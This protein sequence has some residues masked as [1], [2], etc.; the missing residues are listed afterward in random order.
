MYVAPPAGTELHVRFGVAVVVGAAGDGQIELTGDPQIAGGCGRVMIGMVDFEAQQS[1]V[2]QAGED[3][4]FLAGVL[5]TEPNG[6]SDD[7]NAARRADLL[8]GFFNGGFVHGDEGGGVVT[9]VEFKGLVDG[10]DVALVAQEAGEV[11]AAGDG[12]SEGF[13]GGERDIEMEGLEPQHHT[14]VALPAGLLHLAEPIAKRGRRTIAEEVGQQMGG[15]ARVF[16]ESGRDFD[17]A[18]E[19][20]TGYA[21]GF[22]GGEVAVEGVVIGDG[23]GAQ[24][25]EGGLFDEASRRVSAIGVIRMGVKVNQIVKMKFMRLTALIFCFLVLFGCQRKP[26]DDFLIFE[27]D[28]FNGLLAFQ[29]TFGTLSGIHQYDEFL[30]DRSRG[31]IE[32]R[33]EELRVQAARLAALREDT[34][35]VDEAI[36]AEILQKRIEAELLEFTEERSWETNPMLYTGLPGAAIDSLL[37]RDFAPGRERIPAL[38]ERLRTVPRL[39]EAMKMNVRNPPREFT[40][41]AL[42]MAQGSVTYFKQTVPKWAAPFA[43]VEERG[44]VEKAALMAQLAM[45]DAVKWLEKEARPQSKG[46]FA[47]GRERFLKKLRA[48]EMI[49]TPLP[50][51]LAIGEQALVRDRARFAKVAAAFAPAATMAQVMSRLADDHPREGELLSV[52]RGSLERAQKFLMD[53]K[54]ITLP[55]NLRPNVTETP[56]FARNG[57]FASMDSPGAFETRS[58]EAYYYIT[59]PEREWSAVRRREHL[60]L[61]SRPVLEMITIHEAFPGHYVHFLNA[62]RF[63]TKTRKLLT[64]GSTV[65]GWAHYAEQMMM[66]QG[67]GGADPRLE[68][69]QLSEALV[70]DCRFIAGIKLHTEGWSVAQAAKFFAGQAGQEPANAEEEALR[71]TYNPTYL[72]YT[73]GKLMVYELRRDFARERGKNYTLRSFHDTFVRQGGIPLA[74]IRKILLT[75]PTEVR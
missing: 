26:A 73:M 47:L 40:E 23:E 24:T 18:D 13:G 21:R 15:A 74:M 9:E 50:E 17:A 51:L 60:R 62:E 48:E 14:L 10:G 70:R 33:V 7:G 34:L 52:A 71:G 27:E 19:V 56:P 30:E 2:F 67:Y 69:A 65:E 58:T 63:P 36:D 20:E 57:A 53:Q 64:T 11:H 12:A 8:K 72:Y 44:R 45:E 42:R 55:S 61:F 37:K 4:L 16:R 31:R 59:P 46:S 66:E 35:L 28:Y 38:V 3:G 43:T 25:G 29:P 5:E 6:M 39:V 54:L 1:G 32:A 22:D 41:L 75:H 49:D 68:L